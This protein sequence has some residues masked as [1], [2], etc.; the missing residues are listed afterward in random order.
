MFSFRSSGRIHFRAASVLSTTDAPS[1]SLDKEFDAKI[2]SNKRGN[3]NS[4]AVFRNGISVIL[5]SAVQ[6]RRHLAAKKIERGQ[7]PF[8]LLPELEFEAEEFRDGLLGLHGNG[9][10]LEDQIDD[11]AF[12]A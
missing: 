9:D 2:L 6:R 7:S 3:F 11:V 5:K 8:A 4:R 1:R 10:D 12:V